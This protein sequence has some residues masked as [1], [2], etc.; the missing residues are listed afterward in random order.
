[1]KS[2]LPDQDHEP[3][4]GAYLADRRI[5]EPLEAIEVNALDVHQSAPPG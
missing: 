5:G 1:L 3:D 4:A 2:S